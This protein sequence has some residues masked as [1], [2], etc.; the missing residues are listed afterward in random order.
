MEAPMTDFTLETAAT[1]ATAEELDG[2]PMA[3]A[4]RA[5]RGD[6]ARMAYSHEKRQGAKAALSAESMMKLGDAEAAQRYIAAAF[7]WWLPAAVAHYR[8]TGR[9]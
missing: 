1:P 3:D 8:A 9:A 2:M 6:F 7:H 5:L 4:I